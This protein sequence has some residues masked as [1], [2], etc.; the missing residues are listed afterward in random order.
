M[1]TSSLE[2]PLWDLPGELAIPSASSVLPGV[3]GGGLSDLVL[4]DG[5]Y[6]S[7]SV[8]EVEKKKQY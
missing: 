1:W 7:S 8:S 4:F 2:F 5:L 3:D 6:P